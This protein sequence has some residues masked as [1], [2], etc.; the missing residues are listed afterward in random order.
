MVKHFCIKSGLIFK[1]ILIP[2][3]FLH[4]ISLFVY[5]IVYLSKGKYP[6]NEIKKLRPEALRVMNFSYVIK[7]DKCFK[8]LNYKP[9]F[10]LEET[11]VRS[12]QKI[13]N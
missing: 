10:N 13:F 3:F 7:S 11:I 5:V 8:L 6:Q 4:I 1:S 12:I 2:K 9:I